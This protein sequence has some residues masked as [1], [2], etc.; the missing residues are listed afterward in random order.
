MAERNT[1]SWIASSNPMDA[2]SCSHLLVEPSMSVNKNVTVPDGIA[3][4]TKA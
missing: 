1:E 3:T 2:G 4:T